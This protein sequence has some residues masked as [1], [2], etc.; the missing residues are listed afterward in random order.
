MIR[1][2]LT[3]ARV[4]LEDLVGIV[5]LMLPRRRR[6]PERTSSARITVYGQRDVGVCATCE[7]TVWFS[8]RARLASCAKGCTTLTGAELGGMR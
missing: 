4:V 5:A 2:A 7:D 3:V 6:A 8:P 1:A